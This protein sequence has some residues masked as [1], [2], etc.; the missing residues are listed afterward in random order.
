MSG[1]LNKLITDGTAQLVGTVPDCEY[2]IMSITFINDTSE[3]VSPSLWLTTQ[4][5]ATKVDKIEGVVKV[6]AGGRAEYECVNCS[7]G[8]KLYVQAASGCVVRA[9][10]IEKAA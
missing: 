3:E 5:A 2:A 7:A 1:L 9:S 4:S 10:T 8:E 6:V